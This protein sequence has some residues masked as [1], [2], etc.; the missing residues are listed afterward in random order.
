M[1]IGKSDEQIKEREGAMLLQL[2]INEP[3]VILSVFCLQGCSQA[4]DWVPMEATCPKW[5]TYALNTLK[6]DERAWV[7]KRKCQSDAERFFLE[8]LRPFNRLL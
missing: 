6:S 3:F 7:H 8:Q 5:P 1:K 4:H 2:G